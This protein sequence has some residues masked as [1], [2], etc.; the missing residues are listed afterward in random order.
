MMVRMRERLAEGRNAIVLHIWRETTRKLALVF[1]PLVFLL[2]A[3]SREIILFL[4]TARYAGS[5]PVF[6]LWST[7]ILLAALQV[8]SV[9]R[10]YAETKFLLLLSL[11]KLAAIACLVGAFLTHFHLLGPVLVTLL[12]SL[13]GKAV[14]LA[15]MKTLLGT[16]WADLLPWERLVGT[17]GVAAF[18]GAV[19]FAIKLRLHLHSFPTLAITGIVYVAVY[20]AVLWR[21]DLLDENEKSTLT[22]WIKRGAVAVGR[23]A[24]V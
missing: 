13:I 24:E 9:L 19:A 18:A 8:D 17:L 21:A 11:V 2:I 7:S 12:A 15:R 10:V 6:A 16:S 14:S 20:G 22:C 5:V 1:F 23:S 3:C 4:F